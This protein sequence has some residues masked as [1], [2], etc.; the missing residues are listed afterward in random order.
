[1]DDEATQPST[2]QVIDPRRLGRNNSGLNESDLSDVIC[3]LHPASLAAYRVVKDAAAISPEHVLQNEGLSTFDNYESNLD[4]AEQET[5]IIDGERKTTAGNDLALRMSSATKTAYG[6]FFFGRNAGL[7]DIIISKDSA[8]RISNKHF[9]I[10]INMNSVLMAEDVSTNGTVVDDT[11][12][13]CR[14]PR[15]FPSQRMLS[16]GSVIT[17]QSSVDVDMVKFIVRI[18][19]REGHEDEYRDKFRGYVNR[20]AIH[21]ARQKGGPPPKNLG[22]RQFGNSVNAQHAFG[23]VWNGGGKYNVVGR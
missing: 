2:Q 8:K 10:F 5:I 9:R 14:D 23:M 3:I 12:L 17:I 22:G 19:S 13:K 21:D 18:P 16:H 1:M 4:L 7:C 6:G 15:N 11:V 20:C